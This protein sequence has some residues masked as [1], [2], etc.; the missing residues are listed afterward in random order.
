MFGTNINTNSLSFSRII[1]GISKALN[2]ANQLIPIYQQAKPM[3]GNAKK[4]INAFNT[5]N[6]VSIIN[7]DHKKNTQK[8]GSNP[9]F[10]Q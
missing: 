3:I 10:F 1:G 9:V 2:T 4:I 5:V 7:I 6:R 8:I